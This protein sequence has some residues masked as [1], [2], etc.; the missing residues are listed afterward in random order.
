MTFDRVSNW[1]AVDIAEIAIYSI[2]R[3]QAEPRV[4]IIQ[5]MHMLLVAIVASVARQVSALPKSSGVNTQSDVSNGAALFKRQL[6]ATSSFTQVAKPAGCT[7]M[8]D[9]VVVWTAKVEAKIGGHDRMLE[10]VASQY[11]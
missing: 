7:S 3:R 8:I 2:S 1:L 4:S 5:K 10:F 11:A 9:I 6:S